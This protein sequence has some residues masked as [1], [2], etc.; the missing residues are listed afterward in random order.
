MMSSPRQRSVRSR[1]QIRCMRRSW[2]TGRVHAP[3]SQRAQGAEGE[4]TAPSWRSCFRVISFR[5]ISQRNCRRFVAKKRY[6]ASSGLRCAGTDAASRAS[7]SSGVMPP[8]TPYGSRTASAWARHSANT[9]HARHTF[10]AA[11]SRRL[12]AGPRSPS[13]QK[14][15]FGSAVRHKPA[16]CHSHSSARGP[17]NLVITVMPTSPVEDHDQGKAHTSVIY[18]S[19]INPVSTHRRRL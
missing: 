19:N 8:Q 10:F 17:G 9:G 7:R 1:P 11:A 16:S 12:R 6:T 3:T 14:N 4:T 13:G 15:K 2:P 18:K 5:V